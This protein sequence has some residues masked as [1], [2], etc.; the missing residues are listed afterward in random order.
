MKIL[1]KILAIAIAILAFG[2]GHAQQ[3]I[4]VGQTGKDGLS[5]EVNSFFE[6]SGTYNVSDFTASD[7][8]TDKGI[9]TRLLVP[10]YA[11][12]DIVGHP[13]MPAERKLIR[14]PL[15]ADASVIII[16]A[17]YEDID[18]KKEGFPAPVY[19]AQILPRRPPAPQ[20]SR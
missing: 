12:T 9:F 6:F 15:G 19:P 1:N 14:V 13:E 8:F 16:N 2:Q 17:D 20:R 10:G 4:S 5:I 11:K 18:L 7:A 3:I